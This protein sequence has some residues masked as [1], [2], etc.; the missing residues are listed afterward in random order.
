MDCRAALAKT[1][2]GDRFTLSAKAK[3]GLPRFA[4]KGE[5]AWNDGK[6]KIPL[7]FVARGNGVLQERV[8]ENLLK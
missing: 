1:V 2:F 4:C 3:S 5:V 8:A 6:Q 7:A